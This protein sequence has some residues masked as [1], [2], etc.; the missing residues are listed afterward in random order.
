M[1]RSEA[2]R[3]A[4]KRY[5]EKNKGVYANFAIPLKREEK[6]KYEAVLKEYGLGKVE[7]LRWAIAELEKR[8]KN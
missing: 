1:I 6:E 4:D 3:A 2:Q 8:P 7:F 5:A